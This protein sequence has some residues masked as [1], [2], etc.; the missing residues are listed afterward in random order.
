[1]KI[2]VSHPYYLNEYMYF[3]MFILFSDGIPVNKQCVRSGFP[4]GTNIVHGFT[5]GTIGSTICT[6]GNIPMV[7]LGEPRTEP[8][9]GFPLHIGAIYIFFA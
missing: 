6:N 9:S 7:P 8:V 2:G 1:M 4:N 3:F 5:Y